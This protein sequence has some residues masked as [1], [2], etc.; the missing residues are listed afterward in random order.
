M[1]LATVVATLV[2]IST[3]PALAGGSVMARQ[4]VKGTLVVVSP[5]D[6]AGYENYLA[7]MFPKYVLWTDPASPKSSVTL[8]PGMLA[9]TLFLLPSLPEPVLPD[10]SWEASLPVTMDDLNQKGVLIASRVIPTPGQNEGSVSFLIQ[11]PNEQLLKSAL[12]EAL[13]Y[14]HFPLTKPITREAADLRQ[15]R[16]VAC[17]PSSTPRELG[18]VG[19]A[20]E[21]SLYSELVGVHAFQVVGRE[22]LPVSAL[23]P[24]SAEQ[25]RQVGNDIH[26]QAV[27]FAQIASGETVCKDHTEY[28]TTDRK[29]ISDQRQAEWDD[30][31]AKLRAAGKAVPRKGPVPDLVWAAPYLVRQY[32]TTVTGDLRLLEVASGR[33]LVTYSL[34]A[35]VEGDPDS[36]QPRTYDYRWY[37][38]A[39]TESRDS[40]DEQEYRVVFRT[41]EATQAIREKIIGFGK[42]L[43]ARTILPTPSAGE[44][45]AAP[46]GEELRRDARVLE[47]DGRAIFIDLGRAAGVQLGDRFVAWGEK[48]LKDP[49]TGDVI[50]T[51]RARLA[52]LKVVEVFD[53]TSRCELPEGTSPDALKAGMALAKG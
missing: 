20:A 26:A 46:G 48:Q 12:E 9:M 19:E 8:P 29:S 17:L 44:T 10:G 14:E 3:G 36:E 15:M 43:V 13:N 28:K 7:K 18:A 50:E 40:R 41:P 4:A 30:A 52:E 27:A 34:D 21:A 16:T 47:V 37:S 39:D 1:R 22:A 49:E 31:V 42:V 2:V 51:I 5:L 24:M 38:I 23:G 45:A 32:V 6:R 35:K 25:L 53:K 11:A 33:P